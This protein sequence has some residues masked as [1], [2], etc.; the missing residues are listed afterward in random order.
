MADCCCNPLGAAPGST[1]PPVTAADNGDV[2]GVVA[3]TW[4]KAFNGFRAVATVAARNALT[5]TGIVT[6]GML[7][8]VT[9]TQCLYLLNPD[10]ATWTFFAPSPA[11][12]SQAA[13]EVNAATGSDNNSGLPG[14][15]LATTE[16]LSRRLSPGMQL[17]TFRQSTTIS[18]AAGTYGALLLAY[19]VAPA[20]TGITIAFTGTV[21]SVA[22]TLTSVVNTTA[23]TQGR[24]TLAS[25]AG[26]TA[27]MRIRST[28][29]ANIG[30][31]TYGVGALNAA[32]DSF[33]KTW[34]PNTSG[35]LANVNIANG[36]T[37]ALDTLQT[38]I[39]R[40]QLQPTGRAGQVLT[41]FSDII[42]PNGLTLNQDQGSASATAFGCVIGGGRSAGNYRLVN[43][44]LTGSVQ[45]ALLQGIGTPVFAGCCFSQC[46]FITS[47]DAVFNTANAWDASTITVAGTAAVGGSG[48]STLQEWSNGAGLTAVQ[49]AGANN[50]PGACATFYWNGGQIIGFG[51]PYAVG[52]NLDSGTRML[53]NAIANVQIP[54]TQ[55]VIMTGQNQTYAALTNG[56][57]YQRASCFWS[58]FQDTTAAFNNL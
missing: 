24:I 44:K 56:G 18:I 10:L 55:N 5:A 1:L 3:G 45:Y 43:C 25:G 41:T 6:A 14:S 13:W 42:C 35:A 38:T 27:R 20:L 54:S 11:L 16:E 28:S 26:L 2:L 40:V 8:Y 57:D 23:G 31:I 19:T 15:P 51:T 7:A 30:A 49:V 33:V 32:N 34:L 17:C 22:D 47:I 9:E 36:T 46:T 52:Y 12:A 48:T 21:S 50:A 39:N 53:F 37:V 4:Q 29:G 58:K